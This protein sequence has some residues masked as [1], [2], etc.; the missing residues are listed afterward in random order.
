MKGYFYIS[1][2]L[3]L[4]IIESTSFKQEAVK[5]LGKKQSNNLGYSKMSGK[6]LKKYLLNPKVFIVDTR[7]MDISAAGYIPNTIICPTSMYQFLTKIV[8]AGSE[9]IIISD[10]ENY[11]GAIDS[12]ISLKLY[13]LLGYGIYDEINESSSFFI[14]VVEY[15]PNTVESIQEKVDNH[16]NILDIREISE[17]IETGVIKESQLIPLSTFPKDYKKIPDNGNVYVFCK[18]GKRA[19]IGMTYV[20]RAGYPNKF[21][22]MKGGMDQAIEEGYPL[23]PYPGEKL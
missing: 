7:D 9:V 11:Q 22:I 21:V 4:F 14:Q 23:D 15:D 1:I 10:L 20:K 3:L 16:D 17:Y 6:D 19:V 12:L 5:F 18:S 2:I 8:P 13:T